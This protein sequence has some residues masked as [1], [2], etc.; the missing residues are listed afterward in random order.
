MTYLGM[1]QSLIPIVYAIINAVHTIIDFPAGVFEDR[2]R[3]EKVLL[4]GY[5]IFAVS[6]MM[7]GFSADNSLYAFF[8]PLCLGFTLGYQKL[9]RER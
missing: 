5:F 6:T 3:K 9:F 7:M 1:G 4:L 8:W 2:I